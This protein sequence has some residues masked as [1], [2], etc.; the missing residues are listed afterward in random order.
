M[1]KHYGINIKFHLDIVILVIAVAQKDLRFIAI[2]ICYHLGS[3]G[4]YDYTDVVLLLLYYYCI[5]CAS[6]KIS[7]A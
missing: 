3:R 1:L 4:L 6:N 5:I 7:Y 2:E